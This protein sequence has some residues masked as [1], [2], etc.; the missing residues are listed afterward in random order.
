M[1]LL[2]HLGEDA[3]EGRRLFGA[4]DHARD[5]QRGGEPAAEQ[6]RRRVH[7]VQIE[8]GERTVQKVVIVEA[9]ADAFG[10]DIFFQVDAHMVGLA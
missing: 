2:G 3:I 5:E 10:H 8:F 4:A 7:V 9:A 6:T 1:Q